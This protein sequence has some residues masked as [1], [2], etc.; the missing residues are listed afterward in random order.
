MP[1]TTHAVTLNVPAPLYE[2]LKRRAERANRPVEVEL[3]DVL[4]SAVPARDDLPPD[5]EAAISPLTLLDDDSLWRAA[6]SSLAPEVSAELE[7][8]HN[9]QQRQGLTAAEVETLAGLV[10][11]YERAMLVRARAAAILKQ[12]GHDVSQLLARP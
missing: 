2:R 9:K 10:K 8:L 6:R 4:S 11:H 1:M 12:R 7:E 3:L 5:L